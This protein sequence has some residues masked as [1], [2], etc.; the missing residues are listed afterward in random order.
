MSARRAAIVLGAGIAGAAAAYHLARRSFGPVLLYDPRTPA[1]GATGRAAGIVTESL[2]DPWDVAV[3]RASKVE[4]ARLSA[5]HDPPL[6][7]ENGFVRW[8]ADPV[9][10]EALAAAV[11]RWRSWGV[12][13]RPLPLSELATRLPWVATEGLRAAVWDPHD[14]VVA[15][16]ALAE[17]YVAAARALG[18]E[19]RL[20]TP[21]ASLRFANGAW[22]LASGGSTER[23]SVAVVAAGAWSKELLAAV[24]APLPLAP[25]R[26]Q[27]ATLRPPGAVPP[28]FPSFHD[29]DLDVYVR[30]EEAG[31]ALAGD[32]TRLVEV[33]PEAVPSGGDEAFVA[34]LAESLSAR[35]PG[36]ASAELLRAWSGVCTSTPD[37]RPLVGRVPG[38]E[39]LYCLVGFN[40]FGVMRAGG[41]ADRL[42]AAIVD[43]TDGPAGAALAPVRPDR[44][45]PNPPPFAPRP[46]FTLEGGPNPR[47]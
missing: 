41:A 17:A 29:L 24:G 12:A 21:F 46:G 13:A 11:E 34:H 14:A 37:R 1:A 32:G 25:Y 7:R 2:W 5:G 36:W 35:C 40:G 47:F 3:V 30:P 10:A 15:P 9:A 23:A 16:S 33:A 44:F 18:A 27:A 31:R 20:G 4:Y 39:G 26:T 22:E 38:A 28:V 43:G 45:G 8:T 42:A 6:Y 19:V